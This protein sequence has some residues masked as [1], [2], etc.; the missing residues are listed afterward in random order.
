MRMP[1]NMGS[2]HAQPPVGLA[3]TWLAWEIDFPTAGPGSRQPPRAVRQGVVAQL[4][5]RGGASQTGVIRWAVGLG[6]ALG[7][8]RVQTDHP[9][10]TPQPGR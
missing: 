2:D 6:E 4:L 8:S 5:E 3:R 7:G 9:C 10:S 1:I